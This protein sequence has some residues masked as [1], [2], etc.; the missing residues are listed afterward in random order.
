L[1][2]RTKGIGSMGM[3]PS[4]SI[5]KCARQMNHSGSHWGDS[6]DSVF[7]SGNLDDDSSCAVGKIIFPTGKT[8]GGQTTQG[9][10]EIMLRDEFP[11]MN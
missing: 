7:L 9:L 5:V 4:T 8:M 3:L 2:L 10:Y 1:V 11:K 6:V